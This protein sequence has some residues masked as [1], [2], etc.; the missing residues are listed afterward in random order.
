VL[1]V[2]LELERRD[3]KVNV[4]FTVQ[5]GERMALFGPSGAG[6]TS[7]LEM[8]AGLLAPKRGRVH[9]AG[10]ELT[11]VGDGPPV[12]VPPW[13]RRVALLRQNPGLFPHLTV[14]Q[15]IAYTAA[16]VAAGEPALSLMAERL[17]IHDLLH[18]RPRALSGGQAHRV[19][20]ARLLLSGHDALLLD[21]PY[22]GLDARL[23]RILTDV[24]RDESRSRGIPSVLVAHELGEAQAFADRLAVMDRGL[25]LQMGSPAEVVRRPSTK[26]VAQLVGYLGFIP[27]S[28]VSEG[29]ASG[30]RGSSI[31]VH[32]ERVRTGDARPGEIG[33]TGTVT[34]VRPSGTSWEIEVRIGDG[35]DSARLRCLVPDDPPAL[36]ERT[37]VAVTSAPW[38]DAS[39]NLLEASPIRVI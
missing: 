39:G 3:L 15:N 32:P 7:I 16:A 37:G 25:L 38:F 21:E 5:P 20:L 22:T 18:A 4:A 29:G 24:L 17:E 34:D 8:I 36:G 30:P 12:T 10:R 33:M 23:R 11:R 28:A 27:S 31:G 14:R 6:K 9:L 19:A 13:A 26:R 35:E 2:E 1:H